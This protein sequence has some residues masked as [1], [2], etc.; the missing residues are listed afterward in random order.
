MHIH[1]TSQN[2]L[3][4]NWILFGL[5]LNAIHRRWHGWS[6]LNEIV[7]SCVMVSRYVLKCYWYRLISCS[8]HLPTL[9]ACIFD[10]DW[11]PPRFGLA[12]RDQLVSRPA[13]QKLDK[14][15]D[16]RWLK[17]WATS[18]SKCWLG[19]APATL[20]LY[21]KRPCFDTDFF[22]GTNGLPMA[23]P[24]WKFI[25]TRDTL[26]STYQ[27]GRIIA[28]HACLQVLR[29]GIEEAVWKWNPRIFQNVYCIL[30][31]ALTMHHIVHL[32][33][34]L[35]VYEVW[36]VAP[37]FASFLSK[38]WTSRWKTPVLARPLGACACHC[39]DHNRKKFMFGSMLREAGK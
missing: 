33:Y 23:S 11:S 5:L 37:Q 20:S 14:K 6:I 15:L 30:Y 18:L 4:F 13:K 2:P 28:V 16:W 8:Q 35:S 34:I 22:Q 1:K 21:Q 25:V 17:Y 12:S 26:L 19:A 32:L 27:C 36:S 7:T 38:P 10:T 29:M 24:G 9:L 39:L 3:Q 31:T